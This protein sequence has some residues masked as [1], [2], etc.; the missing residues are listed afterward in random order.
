MSTLFLD[1]PAF[2]RCVKVTGFGEKEYW[3]YAE[4]YDIP[5]CHPGDKAF[6]MSLIY[7]KDFKQDGMVF[8]RKNVSLSLAQRNALIKKYTKAYNEEPGETVRRSANNRLLA[9]IENMKINN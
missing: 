8:E 5:D 9:A 7:N 4:S 3:K 2:E 1:S 6:I